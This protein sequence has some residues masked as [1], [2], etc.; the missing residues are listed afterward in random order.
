ML[1]HAF[2]G[3]RA[4]VTKPA[5]LGSCIAPRNFAELCYRASIMRRFFLLLLGILP[6]AACVNESNERPLT[7]DE[8]QR[9]IE[10]AEARGELSA[11]GQV[12]GAQRSGCSNSTRMSRFNARGTGFSGADGF[13][14]RGCGAG[15]N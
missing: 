7:P 6:L 10:A 5:L 13:D 9:M 4:N 2:G 11:D 8:K 15:G 3:V 1:G 12:G 14:S